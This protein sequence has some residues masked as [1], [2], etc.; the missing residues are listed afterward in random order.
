MAARM[1]LGLLAGCLISV[2]PDVPEVEDLE[3]IAVV[4]N[5][6]DA[7]QPDDKCAVRH[8]LAHVDGFDSVRLVSEMGLSYLIR[9]V[10]DGKRHAILFDFALTQQALE[11][12]LHKLGVGLEGVEA[13]VLSHAHEDH[14]AGLI[15]A[16]R[17]TKAP[18]YVGN[19]DAFLERRF[20][21]PKRSWSMGTLRREDLSAAGSR[22]IEVPKPIVIAGG[23]LLSGQIDQATPYEHVPPFLKMIKNGKT[24]QDPMSHELAIGFRVR[25]MGLVVITSCAHAGVINSIEAMRRA[26]GEQTV[27]AVLGGMH[28]TS[29]PADQV[30]ATVQALV[31]LKPSYLAPMHCTGDRAMRKMATALPGAYV[32]PSTGTRYRFGPAGSN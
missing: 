5:T 14:Y 32:H 17:A 3:V 25:G 1:L 13:L 4:D 2:T 29:A 16:A 10:V 18:I 30:E 21:T 24:V 31:A 6:Y 22:I 20:E 27:H 23:A 28:L 7:F 26:S 15:W 11:N 19:S 12:N 8:S 9:Y